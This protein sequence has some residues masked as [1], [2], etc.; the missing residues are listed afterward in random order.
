[1]RTS[2]H[3]VRPRRAPGAPAAALVV[4]LALV[5]ATAACGDDGDDATSSTTTAATTTAPDPEPDPDGTSA[6]T[7]SADGADGDDT[8]TTEAGP[9]TTEAGTGTTGAGADGAGGATEVR[10]A[11]EAEAVL[12]ALLAEYRAALIEVKASGVLDESTVRAFAATFTVDA[13][14]GEVSGL[15]TVGAPATLNPAPPP[16]GASAVTLA[17]AGPRCLSGS[18]HFDGFDTLLTTPS[19]FEQPFHF[20][21]VP[22]PEGAS[23]P[24]WRIDFLRFGDGAGE[25]SRCP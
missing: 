2:R 10:T 4:A 14:R 16:V 9:G 3:A 25:S 20:R 17:E 18:M 11:E 7:G 22:A 8:G 13:A 24:A 12:D 6:P 23:A 1:M 15:E 21:L 19:E 5:L